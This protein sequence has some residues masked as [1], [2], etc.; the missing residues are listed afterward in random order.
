[1]IQSYDMPRNPYANN[2]SNRIEWS[3]VSNALER[4]RKT[5][6][7]VSLFFAALLNLSITVTRAKEFSGMAWTETVLAVGENVVF[8][9]KKKHFVEHQ[10]FYDLRKAR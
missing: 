6:S 5:P 10:S 4:S 2:F 8:I 7:E 9:K 3:I 1:M